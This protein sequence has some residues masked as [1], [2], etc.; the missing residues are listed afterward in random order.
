VF[1]LVSVLAAAPALVVVPSSAGAANAGEFQAGYI[2][3]D[4]LFYNASLMS[5]AQV[6]SFLEGRVQTCRAG[7]GDPGCLKD[8]RTDSAPRAAT[9][10]CGLYQG[11][12]N[13]LASRVIYNVAVACN[14]NPQV[15][16]VL[17]EKEQ[18]LVTSTNP[19]ATRYRIAT[20]Y[21][22]PDTSE[23]DTAYYGFF[24][25]VYSAARQFNRYGDPAQGFR[26]QAGRANTIQWHPNAVCGSSSVVIQNKATA[27]LYN[28]TP[29]QPNAAALTNL[30]GTGD[31]CSSYGN[32]NFWRIFSD[33]FGSPIVS[34]A[35]D[36]FVRAVYQDVLGRQP[37]DG[38]RLGWG[39]ALM[40]GM[41]SWQVAG[42]FVNSDE[43][44]LL[45]IDFAYRDVLGREPEESGRLTWL[46]GM[47]QGVLSP[48]DAYRSFMQSQEYFNSTGGTL[49][50]FVAAVYEKII[51]RPA[52][53]SEVMYWGDIAEE[54]GRETIVD[55]IW[56]SVETARTRVSDMYSAYLGRVPDADGLVGWADGALRNGDSWVRSQILGSVEYWV[57][58]SSRYP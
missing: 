7:A 30:Y 43:F 23:C 45:K 12:T 36:A 10:W 41:P 9:A 48:D 24:N 49:D 19:S 21:G 56:F 38:E 5:E 13:E 34:K 11:G 46:N 18:S 44:R 35:A 39:R 25:Q 28:Y 37:S 33:W 42:G 50:L 22:C 2:I 55:L 58:A 14:I 3:S 54:R 40:S 8:Y 4:E 51:K 15:L 1:G 6:Q 31:S 57:L 32:R 47:R 52:V 20:G 16:L 27:A 26:Y 17:L 29:Y 53:E